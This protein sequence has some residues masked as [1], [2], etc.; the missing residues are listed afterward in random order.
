M[1]DE[2]RNM[3]IEQLASRVTTTESQTVDPEDEV[4]AALAEII[5]NS[6]HAARAREFEDDEEPTTRNPQ[7]PP[8]NLRVGPDCPHTFASPDG[9]QL[10]LRKAPEHKWPHCGIIFTRKR[11]VKRHTRWNSCRMYKERGDAAGGCYTP[12]VYLIDVRKFIVVDGSVMV[13]AL[14]VKRTAN[15]G[16]EDGL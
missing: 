7:A 11:S 12:E 13:E 4:Q 14:A 6:T 15:S 16:D 2:V 1:T 9:V 3:F 8:T 5:A 10:Y